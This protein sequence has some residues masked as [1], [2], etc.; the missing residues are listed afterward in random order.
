MLFLEENLIYNKQD[1][2]LF[3]KC[4]YFEIKMPELRKHETVVAKKLLI[5]HLL[6]IQTRLYNDLFKS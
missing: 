6:K 5:F 1:C 3:K 4:N 2:F